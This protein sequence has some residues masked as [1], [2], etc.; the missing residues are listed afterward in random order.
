MIYKD[1]QARYPNQHLGMA[2]SLLLDLLGNRA[3]GSRGERPGPG[4]LAQIMLVKRDCSCICM[5]RESHVD[6]S[7]E[8]LRRNKNIREVW[9]M[10][11]NMCSNFPINHTEGN[12][13]TFKTNMN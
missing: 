1:P 10:R 8:H 3:L 11:P 4:A 2:Y 6:F 9:S 13:P 12:G 7:L 5:C